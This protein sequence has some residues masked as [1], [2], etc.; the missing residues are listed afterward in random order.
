MEIAMVLL[1]APSPQQHQAPQNIRRNTWGKA[2][3]IQ[4]TSF[5][6]GA[7]I[8]L[9]TPARH[10]LHKRH[11]DTKAMLTASGRSLQLLDPDQL[12]LEERSAHQKGR[13]KHSV[14]LQEDAERLFHSTVGRAWPQSPATSLS[15]PCKRWSHVLG[16]YE[17]E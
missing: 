6:Q 3:R 13:A 8:H 12:L 2:K 1:R 5:L 11:R 10:S 9:M 16:R 14:V 15:A 7:G 17:E 4:Q